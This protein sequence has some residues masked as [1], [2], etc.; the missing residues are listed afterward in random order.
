MMFFFSIICQKSEILTT[1]KSIPR[2]YITSFLKNDGTINIIGN[3][4]F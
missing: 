2:I 3:T 1:E 4:D